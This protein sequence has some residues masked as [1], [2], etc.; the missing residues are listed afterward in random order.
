MVISIK[1]RSMPCLVCFFLAFMTI[2]GCSPSA[3]ARRFFWPPAPEKSIYEF[4]GTYSSVRDLPNTSTPGI[5]SMVIGA[6][7]EDYKLAKPFG[8]V[9]NRPGSILISDPAEKCIKEFVFASHKASSFTAYSDIRSPLGMAHDKSGN[10]YVADSERNKVLVFSSQG[11]YLRSIGDEQ[12][13]DRPAFIAV[14]DQYN[15]IYVSDGRQHRI[16]V[17]S[18]NGNHLFNFGKKGGANGEFAVPQGMAFDDQNRLYVADMLNARIQVFSHDGAFLFTFGLRCINNWCFESPKDIAVS[19]DGNLHI[20]DSRKAQLLTYS[21]NGEYMLTTGGNTRTGHPMGFALPSS[22]KIDENDRI[23]IVDQL[24]RRVSVWQ[25]L[26]DAY[27][28]K[29]TAKLL[30][31]GQPP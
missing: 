25:Y 20:I 22:I 24:N 31:E 9:V 1:F 17:Y 21:P 27:L 5:L 23:F 15:R 29:T 4:I 28:L 2:A 16:C 18:L 14:N 13:I 6:E 7:P 30:R 10:I 3:Q 19:S 26:S 8:L 12:T 11:T